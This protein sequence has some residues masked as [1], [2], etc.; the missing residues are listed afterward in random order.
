MAE[1]QTTPEYRQ[2]VVAEATIPGTTKLFLDDNAIYLDQDE[3]VTKK[4]GGNWDIYDEV[5]F[6]DQVKA[7]FRQRQLA[8]V[9]K[10]LEVL[11]A[12]ETGTEVEAAEQLKKHLQAIN[13]DDITSK[14]MFGIFYG[15][16]VAEACWGL[17][18]EN[19]IGFTAAEET[20]N[21]KPGIYVRQ[22]Y[23]FRFDK[24]GNLRL[25]TQDK[26]QEGV[27][28]PPMKFWTFNSGATSH[29]NPYG[30]GIA[31]DLYWPVFFKRNDIKLWLTFLD[32]F[33]MP[34]AVGDY[35]PGSNE[36]QIRE[37]IKA[38]K[39]IHSESVIAVPRGTAV[40]LIEAARTGAA[41]YED[42]HKVMNEAIAKI[43]VGQ[44]LTIENTGGQYKAEMQKDVRDEIV[45][46][47]G[48]LIC[49]SFNETIARYWTLYNYGPKVKPPRIFRRVKG[50]PDLKPQA[51]RDKVIFDM[52]YE[53][54]EEYIK[55]TY[56]EGFQKRQAPS[57]TPGVNPAIGTPPA[58]FA[59]PGTIFDKMWQA[60]RDQE[61]I[62]SYAAL[63]ANQYEELIGPRLEQILSLAEDS[64]DLETLKQR[65]D[66]LFEDEPVPAAV[67]KVKRAGIV[68]RLMGMLKAQR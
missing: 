16:G 38:L 6:D 42:L 57:F 55:E 58:S 12:L 30:I 20:E 17:T 50:E 8:L 3:I 13:F 4:G 31:R 5:L 24:A 28:M 27:P 45:L 23:R 33:A 1:N 34:T 41:T 19:M 15:Y 64:G 11:P 53:P 2:I 36:K 7:S 56:G 51:D 40:N 66:Q 43:I 67:E 26:P 22:P 68:A 52:G 39:A 62:A 59:E 14:M 48:D 65:I 10:E 49:A 61:A 35:A 46:A 47:D 63:V 44:T 54:T 60:R 21:Y 29:D 32:K 9:S 18:D 25:R 37:V